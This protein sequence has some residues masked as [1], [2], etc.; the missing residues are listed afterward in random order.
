MSNSHKT[1]T[2]V[3]DIIVHHNACKTRGNTRYEG[4][5]SHDDTGLRRFQKASHSY[6]H[7]VLLNWI[8][9]T[10]FRYGKPLVTTTVLWHIRH[11]IHLNIKVVWT[12]TAEFLFLHPE[13][14]SIKNFCR[15]YRPKLKPTAKRICTKRTRKKRKTSV[16]KIN[17]NV[18]NRPCIKIV[19]ILTW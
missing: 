10:M 11:V 9:S 6:T 2:S 5:L 1:V 8:I 3:Q 17:S 18:C 13:I 12:G 7:A 15:Q 16:N 19:L 14:T 4:G